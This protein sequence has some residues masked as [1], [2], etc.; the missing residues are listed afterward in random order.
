MHKYIYYFGKTLSEGDAGMTEIL[1]GKGAHLAQMC[2]IGLP[3]PPGFT[4]S[5]K[6]SS[7]HIGNE[8]HLTQGVLEE[9]E[10]NI[11]KL[12]KETGKTFG[13]GKNP[14]LLSV[15][16]GSKVSMP[17]M[18]DTI[19]N[20]G[21]NDEVV[22]S[23]AESTSD[24]RFAYDCYRR[25]IEMYGSVVLEISHYNFERILEE[26]KEVSGVTSDG[27]L[28]AEQLQEVVKRYKAVIKKYSGH[29][30][31][32]DPFEQLKHA[33]IA[34]LKSWMSPRAI[35][36]RNI[37][38]ISD[39]LGTAINIQTMV[40]GNKGEDSAT[41]VVFTRNPSTGEKKIFG[42]YL[43]NAQGEDVVAGIRTPFPILTHEGDDNNSM[44]SLMNEQYEQLL[45]IC[46]KLETHYEDMQDIEFTI[47]EG[48]LYIL[49]T[50]SGKR[51]TVAAV[52]IAVDMVEESLISKQEALLRIEPES[53]HQLLHTAVDYNSK[54]QVIASG[55]P[56]SPGASTGIVVFSPYD[57]E[58]LSRH[59]KVI[60]VR[61]DTSPED[62]KGM[63]VSAGIITARG[64]MTSHAAVVAR[65][66]GKPCICGI[67]G[68]VV[69]EAS[70]T[71][72]TPAGITIKEG[73]TIT[74]DGSNGKILV[75]EIKLINPEFSGEFKTILKWADEEKRIVV[76]ANAETE[77]DASVAIKFGANGI[78]LCRTEHMFFESNKIPLVREMIIAQTPEQRASAISRLKPLQTEDFRSLFEIMSGLPVNIRLLD[79]PLHEFLPKEESDKL[80]LAQA[81]DVPISLV[82]H[83]LHVLHETNPMLGHRGCRL[84]ISFPEI[85]SMQVE[86]ILEAFQTAKTNKT[87]STIE[88]MVPLICDVQ[89]II[90]L[91]ELI[92]ATISKMEAKYS[93]KFP[94]KIGT[95]IELP[96]AAILASEI[97]EHVEYFSFGSNDLTQTTYGISRDDIGSFM[98]DYIEQ[99]IFTFDPFV[100]IDVI[101][102]GHLIKMAIEKG[103][104]KNAKLTIGICGEH[105]GDPKSIEFF[106]NIGVDYVS[107]S[108]YR[109]P[110]ARI[111]AARSKILLSQG[112]K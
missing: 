81:L 54:P 59:H 111:A 100:H 73:E 90:K 2:K 20:L 39:S 12:E 74:I 52:K 36:Y 30:F 103:K 25:F 29:D 9:L 3:V 107:C 89:E 57:A 32:T 40:F 37:H 16:S 69:N 56:A 99:G 53:L 28:N 87:G 71:F 97:A 60:L 34:V 72:K 88:I 10:Q 46:Q 65:G 70:K 95:M 85:Y 35:A 66:M 38:N 62:I 83:R 4:I 49:Q 17:G 64:G 61:N 68:L 96:R 109:I 106:D 86:A 14:L 7:M 31:E 24:P 75:G 8:N 21:I 33:I 43:I 82:N 45:F 98:P 26:I 55:L 6:I 18:M 44:Q 84:G 48:K 13:S 58:E 108:P 77:L 92:L 104:S 19:L 78:G 76:R 50:R 93:T 11:K 23:L 22:L 91:K 112:S 42:E 67:N 51:S 105:A 94:I 63:H 1:G 41:G 47:E 15:R 110:V 80:A 79:P 27:E 101:G 102:V 5:S